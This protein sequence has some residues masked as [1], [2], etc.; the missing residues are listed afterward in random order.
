MSQLFNKFYPVTD[1]SNAVAI[2]NEVRPTEKQLKWQQM[3]MYGFIHFGMNTF[4]DAEWGDGTADPSLFNPT[5]LD[6]MQWARTAKR[7][8]LGQ[9]ILTAKHHDGFCLWPSKYTEYSVKNSPWKD[10]K[11]DL[12]RE[13]ADACR[14]V[15]IKFG[16]YLSPWDRHEPTYGDSPAYNQYFLNQLTEVLTEYGEVA[17]VWFDGAC[18]E[19]PN[20]KKQEYDFE[21]YYTLIRKLQPDAVIAIMGPD[22]R[23]VGTEEGFGR[24]TEWSVL[25]IEKMDQRVIA[26]NSQQTIELGIFEAS[27]DL[28]KENL[29]SREMIAKSSA[30]AWY[31]SEVDVSIRP[32]WFYHTYQDKDVKTPDQLFQIYLNSVGRNST[33]LLN[34]PPDTRGLLHEVDVA[35]LEG[36]ADQLEAVFGNNLVAKSTLQVPE[37]GY[38]TVAEG[39][40]VTITLD[41][42]ITT[43]CFGI[44]E[45]IAEGQVVENFTLEALVDDNWVTVTE[46]TTIG[47][48]R[49]LTFD[50]I[51]ANTFKV[52]IN[53]TRRDA[54]LTNLGLYTICK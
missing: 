50:N 33:L 44:S 25:P 18:G 36:F 14:E 40:S 5:E 42:P 16:V 20:G 41:A 39:E 4:T 10:G 51:T 29:G 15:G 52:T 11:G 37:C 13:L 53:A 1:P 32:G 3:E 7:A 28:E 19:G 30:L 26:A 2:A 12:V 45:H 21:A 23:W 8:G 17:E 27:F 47:Y 46:G 31:P 24:L 34:L 43:N 6:A 38:I 9:I 49:I 48:R 35:S 54:Y 22:V